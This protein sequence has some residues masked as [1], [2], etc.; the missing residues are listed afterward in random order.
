MRAPPRETALNS[1][2]LTGA[3][4]KQL[5]RG[6]DLPSSTSGDELRQLVEGKVGDFGHEPSHT[7]VLIQPVED[8]VKLRLQDADGVFLTVD[9]LHRE[10]HEVLEEMNGEP[11]GDPELVRL[12]LKVEQ[13]LE[14]RATKECRSQRD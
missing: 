9:P 13:L 8:G 6:L 10:T 12:R 4:L 7:R 5:A 2:R 11:E 3:L 1:K 14:Q